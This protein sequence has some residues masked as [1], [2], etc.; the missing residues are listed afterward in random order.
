MGGRGGL[1]LAKFLEGL[2]RPDN[3]YTS[4]GMSQPSGP[5]LNIWSYFPIQCSQISEIALLF[6]RLPGFGRLSVWYEQHVDEDE[7]EALLTWCWSGKPTYSLTKRPSH[8]VRHISYK[9]WPGTVGR[10]S[11]V[12][13]TTRYGL[14]DQGIESRW[15]RDFPRPSRWDLRSTQPPVQ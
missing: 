8:P 13:I 12:G 2:V 15:Q 7:C 3:I 11:A 5:D 1:L 14:N 9:C 6:G 4:D 10:D